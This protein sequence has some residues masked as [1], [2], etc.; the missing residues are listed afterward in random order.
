MKTSKEQKMKAQNGTLEQLALSYATFLHQ[1]DAAGLRGLFHP[2]SD[3]RWQED[4]QLKTITAAQFLELVGQSPSAQS[5]G[6]PEDNFIITL[7]RSDE[8]TGFVKIRLRI[9]PKI[10]TDYLLAL[11]LDEGWTIVSKIFRAEST[12]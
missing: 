5:Q 7:D 4:G 2:S 6:H 8:N 10:Y 1:G 12:E 9:P 3:L 11:K